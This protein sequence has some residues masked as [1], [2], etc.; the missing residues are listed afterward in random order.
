MAKELDQ[1]KLTMFSAQELKTDYKTVHFFEHTTVL[2][3]KMLG[4]NV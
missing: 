1:F 2:T 3:L 4:L